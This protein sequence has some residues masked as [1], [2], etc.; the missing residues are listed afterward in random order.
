MPRPPSRRPRLGFLLA[1]L[2]LGFSVLFLVVRL[3]VHEAELERVEASLRERVR[4]PEEAFEL[5]EIL[6]DRSLRIALREVAILGEAGDTVVSAPRMRLVFDAASLVGDGPLVFRDVVVEDPLLSLVKQADGEWNV[7]RAFELQVAGETV[8]GAEEV[9][10]GIILGDVRITGGRLLLATPWNPADSASLLAS[11]DP[12][13]AQI[14][15]STM[16]V[17]TARALEARIPMARFGGEDGWRVEIAQATALLTD[18]EVGEVALRGWAEEAGEG[19]RFALDQLR[20]GRS[21]IAGRGTVGLGG[22]IP[23]YDLTLRAAPLA[24]ADLR[25]LRPG[26]TEEG[27][28]RFEVHVDSRPGGRTAFAFRDAE[29]RVRGSR[30]SGQLTVITAE[31]ADPVFVDTRVALEP[32]LL[33]DL[34]ALGLVES[35]PYTGRVTG[36]LASVSAMEGAEGSLR[37]DLSAAVTPAAFPEVPASELTMRGLVSLGGEDASIRFRD[38]RVEAEPL[39]LAALSPFMEQGRER[40]RGVIRGSALLSG[41]PADLRIGSGLLSYEVGDAPPTRLRISAARIS[42]QPTLTYSVEARA[43]PLA[44]AT[45]TEL[46]P[47]LPFRDET[48]GGPLTVSGNQEGV[49]FDADLSGSAGG[50]ALR[51]TASFGEPLRFD[52]SGSLQA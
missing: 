2:L 16:V 44:L 37:I 34:E 47:S 12:Q 41:T 43:E 1:G 30:A 38:L 48:L 45:L 14:G 10:R 13:L 5:E 21:R 50:I 17:R 29:I 24:L 8:G 4:L 36:T 31:N 20:T 6:P 39:Y 23:D 9:G 33:S 25:W 26:L 27:A 42:T 22:E 35:L 11:P 32:L 46:F 49:R 18:P 51:G 40:L 7:M 28:A 52:V 15:G 3:F 19:F